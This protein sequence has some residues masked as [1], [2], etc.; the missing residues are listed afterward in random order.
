[1]KL[2]TFFGAASI[3]I[4]YTIIPFTSLKTTNSFEICVIIG[5]TFIIYGIFGIWFEMNNKDER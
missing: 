4:I 1:M 2:K 5:F 3:T